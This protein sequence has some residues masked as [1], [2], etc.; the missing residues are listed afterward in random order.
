MCCAP[1]MPCLGLPDTPAPSNFWRD[2]LAGARA[3]TAQLSAPVVWRDVQ[4]RVVIAQALATGADL[5][6]ADEPATALD[7]TIGAQVLALLRSLVQTRGLTILMITHDMDVVAEVC[8][9]ATV[10]C[11]WHLRLKTGLWPGFWRT[12]ATLTPV[13]CWPPC[14]TASPHGAKLAAIEGRIPPPAELITGCAFAA[15]RGGP[16]RMRPSSP[17][18]TVG[19]GTSLDLSCRK[20]PR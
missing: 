11:T 1:I 4:Q 19:R 5:L 9:S 10:L 16:G 13:R 2:G 18:R 8:D 3:G 17:A 20:G 6:I 12:P 7:V 14:R 15:L